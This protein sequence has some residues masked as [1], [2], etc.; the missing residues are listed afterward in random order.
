MATPKLTITPAPGRFG[1]LYYMK[2]NDKQVL[3]RDLDLSDEKHYGKRLRDAIKN[4]PQQALKLGVYAKSGTSRKLVDTLNVHTPRALAGPEPSFSDN[5]A[6][7]SPATRRQQLAPPQG[8]SQV[9]NFLFT[10]QEQRIQDKDESLREV[11]D[12]LRISQ[13]NE[14]RLERENAKIQRDLD[15][16]DARHE[17]AIQK[18]ELEGRENAASQPTGLAGTFS[19]IVSAL[20]EEHAGT[21]INGVLGMVL[22]RFAPRPAAAPQLGSAGSEAQRNLLNAVSGWAGTSDEVANR[23]FNILNTAIGRPGGLE[24]LEQ[25][26]MQHFTTMRA[27]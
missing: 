3:A 6:T 13:D 24:E 27:A 7:D 16:S 21:I 8:G 25:L 18:L 11:R 9:D 23:I 19:S 14:K 26:V 2:G 1:Q 4:Y 20:P 15:L 12:V 17:L 5:M 10:F 22:D